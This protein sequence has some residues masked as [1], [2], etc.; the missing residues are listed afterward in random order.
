MIEKMDEKIIKYLGGCLPEK[1]RL[2]LLKEAENNPSLKKDILA[3]Q[4]V[5]A[6][7]SLATEIIDL[8]AGKD[9]Y[10]RLL[11]TVRKKKRT[12]RL[13]MAAGYAAAVCLAVVVTRLVMAPDQPPVEPR[14]AHMQELYVP[15]GQRARITLPDGTTAWLN[16]GST[17]HYPS[18]FG[19]ERNVELTGEAYFDVAKNPDKPFVVSTESF[20]IKALGTQFNVFS[21]PKA[22]YVSATLVDGAVEVYKPGEESAAISL[23]PNQQI[24]YENGQ[25]RIEG[26]ADKDKLMWKEGIYTFRKE[27]IAKII[28]KLE[29]YYDVEIIVKN[30]QILKYEYTGKFRQRD[31]VMEILQIIRKI[32]KFNIK[33]DDDRNVITLS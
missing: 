3:Y 23:R 11:H 9:S 20:R 14:T 33:K 17:L 19:D 10:R 7:L 32:H 27:N 30:P 4:Q 18:F 28:K 5:Y 2:A 8:A 12:Y 31:G 26:L 24:Y 25:F 1:E 29:L 13:R 21:Y 22:D 16:A 6:L 15:A